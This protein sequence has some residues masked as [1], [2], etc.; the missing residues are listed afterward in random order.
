MQGLIDE[1]DQDFSHRIDKIKKL[2]SD[3]QNSYK[4]SNQIIVE[5]VNVL[6]PN[7]DSAQRECL[8]PSFIIHYWIITFLWIS[9]M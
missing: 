6:K 2:L 4:K 1:K 5:T 3:N 9:H 8:A 7:L